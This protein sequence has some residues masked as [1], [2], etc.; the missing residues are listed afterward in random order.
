MFR[1]YGRI[2]LH[3]SHIK[4][5]NAY[6]MYNLAYISMITSILFR[7]ICGKVHIFL[8]CILYTTKIQVFVRLMTIPDC[9]KYICVCSLLPLSY[10]EAILFHRF[11]LIFIFLAVGIRSPGRLYIY[12]ALSLLPNGNRTFH[13]SNSSFQ[14]CF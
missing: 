13:F 14:F 6:I 12:S 8:F 7:K 11:L 5:L 3:N 2:M 1:T 9:L 4:N 10:M